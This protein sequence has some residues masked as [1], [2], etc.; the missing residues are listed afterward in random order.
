MIIKEHIRKRG[1]ALYAIYLEANF[2]NNIGNKTVVFLQTLIT[3]VD[4]A[5]E[6]SAL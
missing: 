5:E 1:K 3:P 2:G 6:V 4:L